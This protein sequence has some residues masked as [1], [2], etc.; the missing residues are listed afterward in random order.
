M[1]EGK[2]DTKTK[3]TAVLGLS[4]TEIIEIINNKKAKFLEAVNFNSPS[5]TVISGNTDEIEA[6]KNDLEKAGAKRVID[7]SV[8]VPSHSSLMAIASTKLRLVLDEIKLNKPIFPIIQ[9]FHAKVPI[10][11]TEI[12]DNLSNQISKPVQWVSSMQRLKKYGLDMHLEFGPNKVLSGLAKQNR[13]T[14]EFISLDNIDR[15]KELLAT[16]GK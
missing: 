16:Y 14:G 10:T 11:L 12:A 13:V 5:Q 8:S 9:N 2:G 6:I 7:L 3:M 15:F 4:G 1:I